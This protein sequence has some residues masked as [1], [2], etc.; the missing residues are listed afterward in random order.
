MVYHVERLGDVV[1]VDII[2]LDGRVCT[3]TQYPSY[4]PDCIARDFLACIRLLPT[5]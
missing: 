3:F 4:L 1:T 5:G 2:N